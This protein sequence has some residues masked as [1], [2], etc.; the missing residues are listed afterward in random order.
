[1]QRVTV[2]N[3]QSRYSERLTID[4]ILPGDNPSELIDNIF[5]LFMAS[6]VRLLIMKHKYRC[7]LYIMIWRE[8]T[9]SF[10][11]FQAQDNY[12]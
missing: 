8:I 1:M 2:L 7:L 3:A 6:L 5:F 9:N 11:I 4:P 12:K 10:S